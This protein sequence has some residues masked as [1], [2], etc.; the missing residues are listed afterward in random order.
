MTSIKTTVAQTAPSSS[1]SP[2]T[3]ASRTVPI[4]ESLH[5]VPG[6]PEKLKIYRIAASR[7]W[8]IRLYDEHAK[9]TIKRSSQSEHKA[10]AFKAAKAL[11]EQVVFQRLIGASTSAKSRFDV[12]AKAM[13]EL[14]Q[15][16]VV[17]KELS[18]AA[19]QNDQYFLEATI[20]PR[21]R[22]LDVADVT[23]DEL[24]KFVAKL[25]ET[26]SGSSILRYLG[27]VRKVLEYARNRHLLQ[28]LPQF[29]KVQKQDQP[30]GWFRPSEYNALLARAKQ[31][32]G[33]VV[34]F[35]PATDA[36]TGKRQEVRRVTI[37]SDLPNMI[38]F[39]V[40]GFIRPTDLKNMRHKHIEIIRGDHTFLRL[41][42]PESKKHD[43]PIVTLE[44]A[45]AIYEEIQTE[46]TKSELAA[47]DDYVFMPT[48]T[49][50][51][52]A[53]RKLQQQFNYVLQDLN[54]KK[55]AL[56]E[57]RTIYSLRHTC[58]M[59]RLLEG[60]NIDLLTL[61]RNARTSVEMIER[62]YASQLSGEM[63]I[64]ALQSN[65][66]KK[67]FKLTQDNDPKM[68]LALQNGQ[69]ILGAAQNT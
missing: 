41:T 31:L 28:T 60:D 33:Q 56:D 42:L 40:N 27:L 43:K 65:R 35:Q 10:E 11:Y 7:F 54:F 23:F 32:V 9:K 14:Q 30:R 49:N 48:Y 34:E 52:T 50:R 63:N 12:C 62:F 22:T 13:M 53:L 68:R 59:F 38:A 58:I 26:L 64:D 25:G 6:Y 18:L 36:A 55:G 66:T 1:I 3:K 46:N 4:P 24:E 17:R 47:P 69:I 15:S 5:H 51:E 29:P 16:R 20:L 21:F 39:M 2:P 57:D 44:K 19:H 67:A 37:T 61:A 8:Q 45:V